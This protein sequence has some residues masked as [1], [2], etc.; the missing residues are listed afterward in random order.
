MFVKAK[1]F[2]PWPPAGKTKPTTNY[3][4]LYQATKTSTQWIKQ[5]DDKVVRVL[6]ATSIEREKLQKGRPGI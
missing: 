2:Y 1:R 6:E 4:L 3:K 5:P